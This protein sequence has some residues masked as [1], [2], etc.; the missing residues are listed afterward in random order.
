MF[1]QGSLPVIDLVQPERELFVSR[2][3]WPGISHWLWLVLMLAG[4]KVSADE[5]LQPIDIAVG[6]WA[7]FVTQYDEGY[8]HVTEK[9]TVVLERMGYR[10]NYLF[11]PWSQAK[12]KVRYND[13]QTGPQATFPHLRTEER[14]KH[15]LISSKPIYEGCIRFFYNRRKLSGPVNVS[16]LED[17]AAY[18]IGWVLGVSRDTEAKD[19]CDK[20][21]MPTECCDKDPMPTECC[22]KD[23]MPTECFNKGTYQYPEDLKKALNGNDLGFE[24]QY[25]AFKHLVNEDD[26]DVA[27]VP[28]IKEAG[29]ELL[30]TLFPKDRFDIKIVGELS[31][32]DKNA[33][34]APPVHYYFLASR[35]N[36]RNEEFMDKFDE[37]YAEIDQETMDRID[38]HADE[39]PSMRQPEVVLTTGD[40]AMVIV[41]R[42]KDDGTACHFPRGSRGLLLDWQPVMTDDITTSEPVATVKLITGSCRGKVLQIERKYV[43][44]R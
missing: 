13:E 3:S 44:L 1:D 28:A 37:K 4:C 16:T 42:D 31:G 6:E 17:L 40:K 25:E 14:E 12:L 9:V 36:P 23:P 39:M 27:I 20:D 26:E 18:R 15:F 8:G 38:R 33:C 22:Y 29:Y 24:T 35:K 43:E 19:T 5:V 32:D 41:G 10:P 2:C 30:Y 11:M 21:P 34:L 7:P